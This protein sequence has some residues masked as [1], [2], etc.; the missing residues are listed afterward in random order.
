MATEVCTPRVLIGERDPA[1]TEALSSVVRRLNLEPLFAGDADALLAAARS[2]PSSIDLAILSAD[3]EPDPR[4]K[5][6]RA[7]M[8]LQP[9]AEL[10]LLSAGA[11]GEA[12]EEALGLG[13]FAC[14][15][16]APLDAAQLT[17]TLR[18]ATTLISLRRE[19]HRLAHELSA[20]NERFSLA[21]SGAHDGLFDWD[22]GSGR[23]LY[24]ARW[25]ALLGYRE[26]EIGN[27][28][29]EWLQRLS[30]D[31]R[32]SVL[33]ALEEFR[34]GGQKS[35]RV[36]YRIRAKDGRLRWMSCRAHGVRNEHKQLLRLVG[37]QADISVQ[38]SLEQQLSEALTYDQLTGLPGQALFRDRLK[39]TFARYQRQ[40]ERLFAVCF[41]SVDNIRIINESLG[42]V[43][44]DQ[45][46]AYVAGQL[47]R[48]VRT[49][50]TVARF[51]G[52]T[53]SILLEGID[54][55]ESAAVVA[56]R[57]LKALRSPVQLSGQEVFTSAS[58]GIGTVRPDLAA[59]DAL[60]RAADTANRVAK[61]RGG[62]RYEFFD[63]TMHTQAVQRLHLHSALH[64]ALERNEL[65]LYYQPIIDLETLAPVGFEALLRWQHPAEGLVSPA[66]FIPIAEETGLIL[67]MGRW[68]LAEA[69]RQLRAWQ[70]RFP[71]AN[72]WVSV[73]VSAKQFD[74]EGF[75]DAV[76]EG[77]K[78]SGI[79]PSSLKLEITESALVSDDAR[80][81]RFLS[82]LRN[83]GVK[84]CLDDFGTGYSSFSY[85]HRFSIDV[86][87]I[88]RS[89]IKRLETGRMHKILRSIVSLARRLGIA[90]VAEGVEVPEQ[91]AVLR[92]L[93]CNFGQGFFFARPMDNA[94]A[95]SWLA[96]RLT[97]SDGAAELSPAVAP[98][99]SEPTGTALLMIDDEQLASV[100]SAALKQLGMEAVPCRGL[101][102]LLAK[103]AEARVV[104]HD[105]KSAM[106][107]RADNAGAWEAIIHDA[108]APPMLMLYQGGDSRGHE[109]LFAANCWQN[110]LMSTGAL[111]EEQATSMIRRLVHGGHLGIENNLRDG[112]AISTGSFRTGQEKDELLRGFEQFLERLGC[113]PSFTSRVIT[114]ADEF[115]L[116]AIYS[117]P[118]PAAAEVATGDAGGEVGRQ[119]PSEPLDKSV[120]LAFGSDGKRVVVACRDSLGTL[121]RFGVTASLRRGIGLQPRA[122]SENAGLGI[123]LYV[124]FRY[125][126][127]LLVT[128]HPGAATE[129]IGVASIDPSRRTRTSQSNCL[130]VS[131]LRST[132]R[133][134]ERS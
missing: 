40:P 98:Q 81:E 20:A 71:A 69:C 72:L 11:A 7:F 30:D 34:A 130:A 117:H 48:C 90:I 91:L 31:D 3:L 123:G 59:G 115:A 33:A 14:L 17:L 124:A 77:L 87:K 99:A 8:L 64:R 114:V 42:H 126:D 24:S 102:E 65:R 35:F 16:K 105:F 12:A 44:G 129:I 32:Q 86:L 2:R 107:C 122:L 106:G 93:D 96:K 113:S 131:T 56:G 53:F 47:Q 120:T 37:S 82:A 29:D 10:I 73:N 97:E 15:S 88:D 58:V 6:L 110:L 52:D 70:E 125:M 133:T 74:D 22:L 89:F 76:A 85:L 9:E 132:L 100:A 66:E 19:H 75:V 55:T 5:A 50:D 80:A 92:N 127:E 36:S 116:N 46:L 1:L 18:S 103:R 4:T 61:A 25:K 112:A 26:H 94:S 57:I 67:P 95:T 54:N 83:L 119:P 45:M 79:V 111:G 121:E 39:R 49:V 62:D 51:G 13:A 109:E 27:H 104:M 101:P 60:E 128:M 23:V 134:K 28:I 38:K 63:E 78:S 43:V 84:T 41:V 21:A 68:V 108:S 118:R